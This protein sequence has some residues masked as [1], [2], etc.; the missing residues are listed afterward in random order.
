MLRSCCIATVSISPTRTRSPLR[1]NP[2]RVFSR[3]AGIEEKARGLIRFDLLQTHPSSESRVK[4]IT[5]TFSTQ[6]A[7]T[8][9]S[10][11]W[12][13]VFQKATQSWNPIPNVFFFAAS[14]MTS[15]NLRVKLGLRIL[16]WNSYKSVVIFIN[17]GGNK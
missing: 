8:S 2:Y 9:T 15:R 6:A 11:F 13:N 10:S 5:S 17:D 16:G 4:V 1:H 14:W 7:D 12:K 3:L